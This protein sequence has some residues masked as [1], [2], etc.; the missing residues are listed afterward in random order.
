M[1]AVQLGNDV[2]D[3]GLS[4]TR[5]KSADLRFLARVLTVAEQ[6]LVRDADDPDL[7]LWCLWA[8]KEAGYKI[9]AKLGSTVFSHRTFAVSWDRPPI[10]GE[11][12]AGAVCHR[13]LV[14]S[15]RW[16]LAGQCLHSTGAFGLSPSELGAIASAATGWDDP[17]IAETAAPSEREAAS[18][19]MPGSRQARALARWLLAKR[20][21]DEAQIVRERGPRGW[22]PP[23]V[24]R[25]GERDPDCDVSLSHHGRFVGAA[26]WAGGATP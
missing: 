15:V 22:G 6:A 4:E 13:D 17:R 16:E 12:A 14:I 5:G 18:A 21:I 25:R 26:I 11:R 7:A 8:A 2:V 19:T 20:G 23:Q 24:W 9:A 1:S 3:L 10:L